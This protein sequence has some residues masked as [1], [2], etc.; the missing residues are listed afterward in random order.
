MLLLFASDQKTSRVFRVTAAQS[1]L[2]EVWRRKTDKDSE[3]IL[4]VSNDYKKGSKGSPYSTT[5]RMV[6]S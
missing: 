6:R 2:R 3:H 4:C 5:E 1:Y